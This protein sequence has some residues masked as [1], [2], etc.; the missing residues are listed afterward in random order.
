MAVSGWERRAGE[1]LGGELGSGVRLTSR[2]VGVASLTL[3]GL[4]FIWPLLGGP[5]VPFVPFVPPLVERM[6]V[7]RSRAWT[8]ARGAM[9][10]ACF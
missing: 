2:S 7:V 3:R 8:R 4:S 6:V 5:C 1:R 10:A 9:A